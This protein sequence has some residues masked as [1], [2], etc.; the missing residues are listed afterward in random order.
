MTESTV[1]TQRAYVVTDPAAGDT[2]IVNT[3]RAY[4]VT[5][6]SYGD[7]SN[8]NLQRSYV[9]TRPLDEG[10][11]GQ[12][13]PT[14]SPNYIVENG[15]PYV[16][17]DP[18][19]NDKQLFFYPSTE[20][21][22]REI[23]PVNYWRYFST[24]GDR[25]RFADIYFQD[26][27]GV[28]IPGDYSVLGGT[29]YGAYTNANG[30]DGDPATAW[31]SLGA[32]GWVGK[33]FADPKL[34]KKYRIEAMTNT[35]YTDENPSS[36][37]IEFSYD[38]VTWIT[39]DE[40]NLGRDMSPSEVYEG[41]L[42]NSALTTVGQYEIIALRPNLL[43]FY[44][45]SQT[46]SGP[47]QLIAPHFNQ[48]FM[49]DRT[50]EDA[51][52]NQIKST[53]L[54]RATG[55]GVDIEVF[56]TET[57]DLSIV[58][59]GAETGDTTGWTVSGGF[60]TRTGAVGET[61]GAYEGTYYFYGGNSTASSSAYQ[62]IDVSASAS[63]VNVTWQQSHYSGDDKANIRLEFY[64][65]VDV[66]FARYWRVFVTAASDSNYDGTAVAEIEFQSA[67]VEILTGTPISGPLYSGFSS[68]DA[69]DNNVSTEA[70][71]DGGTLSGGTAW[72][73]K[74]FGSAVQLSGYGLT[75]RQGEI[76][77]SPTA[78]DL[79]YSSDGVS[80]TT[81]TSDTDTSQNVGAGVFYSLVAGTL[82]G[83]NP[84]PGLSAHTGGWLTR[85][86]GNVDLPA[87]TDTVRIIIDTQ[88]FSG[89]NNDAYIDAISASVAVKNPSENSVPGGLQDPYISGFLGNP[90]SGI[91]LVF[92]SLNLMSFVDD[93]EPYTAVSANQGQPGTTAFVRWE[94]FNDCTVTYEV[95]VS[96][97]TNFD[98]GGMK[99]NGAV[100]QQTSGVDTISGSFVASQGDVVDFYYQKDGSAD[101][102]ADTATLVSLT[103]VAS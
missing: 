2:T 34:V 17:F 95:S 41:T 82:L 48:V 50:L 102:N 85:T 98:F 33:N 27:N 84:G 100:V 86:T 8:V 12:A 77:Q 57:T 60:T 18:N 22:L 55:S 7:F 87:E 96:S 30:L 89:S 3:Q 24:K 40:V 76:Y 83:S 90:A 75:G 61:P 97:E 59:P 11:L 63:S 36:W 5:D 70:A 93:G 69:F 58:N 43:D 16:K 29:Y 92:N 81:F 53:M 51:E 31:V 64:S 13:D 42:P 99:L 65:L 6:P 88:R 101:R 73:G 52:R 1:N 72:F 35:N 44:E 49:A 37:R 68:A 32:N 10:G 23:K 26:E 46:F 9:V 74:D 71:T 47:E 78:W 20:P 39:A 19:T 56:D 103:T 67:E 79:Q 91:T 54:A 94:C 4:V 66:P 21:K 45:A 28:T 15:T 14:K 62:D 25:D 80:W 38:G